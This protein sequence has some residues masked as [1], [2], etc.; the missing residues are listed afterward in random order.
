[1]NGPFISKRPYY[2]PHPIIYIYFFIF[3]VVNN[4]YYYFFFN[5]LLLVLTHMIKYIPGPPSTH[6]I[7]GSSG[8]ISLN[9]VPVFVTN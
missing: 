7:T 5:L 1:M 6:I 4:Y 8:D 2:D 9:F 3:F